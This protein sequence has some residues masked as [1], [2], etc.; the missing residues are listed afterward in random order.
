MLEI[1]LISNFY[2]KLS[3]I[4]TFGYRIFKIGLTI[5]RGLTL[6]L[7]LLGKVEFVLLG[8]PYS[9]MVALGDSL[10]SSSSSEILTGGPN[11]MDF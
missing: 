5:F 9:R 1:F 3:L 7:D 11:S 2:P 6:S 8:A 10:H 4:S